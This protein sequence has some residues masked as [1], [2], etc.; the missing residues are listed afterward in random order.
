M[1]S[2]SMKHHVVCDIQHILQAHIVQ[3]THYDSRLDQSRLD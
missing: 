3:L 2:I 1:I